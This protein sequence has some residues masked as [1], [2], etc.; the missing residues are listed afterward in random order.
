LRIKHLCI[1]EPLVTNYRLPVYAELSRHCKVDWLFSPAMG[2][3][4]FGRAD[5]PEERNLHY[6]EIPM[7]RPFGEEWGTIQWGLAKYILREKPDAIL[8]SAN[9]NSLSLWSTLLL[10]R[11]KGIPFY[12]HGHGFFKKRKVD[13]LR[14]EMMK[15][16]LQLVTSYIAYAPAVRDSFAIHGISV[17]KI[18]VAHNSLINSSPVRP[19]EKTGRERG[20]L[21][22]GR[23]RPGNGLRLLLRVVRRLHEEDGFPVT[24][25]V[26]GA[27]E[28]AHQLRQEAAGSSWVTWHGEVYD[29]RNIRAISLQCFLGCYPGNA[30]ISVVHMMSLSL[31]VVT[32]D[33]APRHGPESSFIR[34]GPSSMLFDHR[35]P[36]ESLHRVLRTLAAE[37]SRVAAMQ[38]SVFEDYQSL[39]NP[40]LAERLWAIL[41]AGHGAAAANLSAADPWGA[42][43]KCS[44][45]ALELKRESLQGSGGKSTE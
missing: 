4:G 30:G 10:A 21:F 31:P 33:D 2:E 3:S 18:S 41:S 45:H 42:G 44:E 37:P 22:I 5:R 7:L 12:A 15:L 40:S 34:N 43:A 11:L 1:I 9:L 38:R 27:G 36:E 39:V 6:I 16:L 14:R 29:P 24:L 13:T 19:E 28:E 26:I 23:L 8:A 20:I 17:E 35:S 25:Q 32:H